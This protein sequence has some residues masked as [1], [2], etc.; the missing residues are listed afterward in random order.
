MLAILKMLLVNLLIMDHMINSLF[1]KLNVEPILFLLIY[2]EIGEDSKLKEDILKEN[3]KLLSLL[4]KQ[5][6]LNP[7]EKK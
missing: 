1:V 2:S 3:G 7:M 4:L 5:Q 6:L